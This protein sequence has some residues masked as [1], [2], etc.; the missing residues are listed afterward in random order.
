MQEMLLNC[1][2]MENRNMENT[3][4]AQVF[5]KEAM[6]LD[7]EP[8]KDKDEM[9]SF[10]T[11]RF[12]EAGIATD[13]EAYLKALYEREE[14]GP[15]YMGNKI[16]LPHGKSNAVVAPGI[17]F[18]RCTQPFIYDSCG[19]CGE[20]KYVFML[21]I[22]GNQTG[23]QYMRVLATL[24]GLLAHEDFISSLDKCQNYEDV[25]KKIKKFSR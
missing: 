18:C 1:L 13:K 20:V 17:G 12:V 19:E 10:M 21:A 11:D 23:E 22:A 2:R 7:Q 9:F 15:T 25:M 3:N 6:C 8:F 14:L 5:V 24:A 16:G 4:L